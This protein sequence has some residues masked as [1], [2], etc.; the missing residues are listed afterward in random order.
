MVGRFYSN[1]ST[2]HINKPLSFQTLIIQKLAPSNEYIVNIK[3]AKLLLKGFTSYYIIY[4]AIQ[5]EDSNNYLYL[6]Q[7]G[8]SNIL[9]KYL[10][11]YL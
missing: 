6:K 1:H 5:T 11:Y 4:F 8:L 9:N 7:G 10:C 2:T 3:I